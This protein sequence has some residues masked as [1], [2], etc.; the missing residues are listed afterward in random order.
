MSARRVVVIGYGMAGARLAEEVRRRDRTGERVALSVVGAEPH[1]AYNRVLL[2]SVVA[3][4][5]TPES[6]RLQEPDWAVRHHVDLRLGMSVTGVDRT[7]RTVAL[8]DGSALDYDAL[9]LATGST[10]WVPPTEGLRGEDG[11]LAD[12]VACF[13]DLDDCA[14]ILARARPGA[15]VVVLGG[16]LLGLEAARGLAGRGSLVTVVHP[17]GHLMERQLDPGAGTV[18]AAALAGLGI[19]FRLNRVAARYV[20]GDGLKLDDGSH[21]PA[22]LVVVSAGVRAETGL[23]AAIGLEVDRG[24]VV[25]DALRT[26]DP[27]VHAIGDCAQHPGTV[28]GLVQPAWEQAE[29]LADLLTGTAPAARYRGTPVVTRL[30]A[31]GI[32]LAALG[33]VHAEVCDPGA[34][35]LCLQDPS[36]G[37]YAKLVLRED[38]V[39]GAILLGVPDAAAAITQLYDAKTPAPADRLAL[40]LGRALPAAGTPAHSPAELPAGAVVCRCNTVSKGQLVK[41]WRG[42]ACSVADLATATRATT[43]CGGCS[44]AV[45]G[46]ADWL[47]KS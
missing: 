30:K 14:A 45:R 42:G 15:P 17:V 39:T 32:D 27:R 13:R 36:R 28:S 25:D 10:A 46:I 41:A 44:E 24:V 11:A 2:S 23:A 31:R 47:A 6:V 29:V 18:L 19:E 33:E 8:A 21:L 26:S 12:G 3:G 43:G 40:L 34:E 16:G 4:T 37:R 1:A 9:V 5:M 38:R 20:P 35:V 22:D 7:A